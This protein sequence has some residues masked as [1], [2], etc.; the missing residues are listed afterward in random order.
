MVSKTQCLM[1]EDIT[2]GFPYN[3]TILEPL[4][5]MSQTSDIVVICVNSA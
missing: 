3:L 4:I 2:I 1:S 5:L